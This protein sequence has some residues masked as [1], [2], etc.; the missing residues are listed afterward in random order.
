MATRR[1][2]HR[3]EMQRMPARTPAPPEAPL[4][5]APIPIGFMEIIQVRDVRFLG[6]IPFVTDTADEFVLERTVPCMIWNPVEMSDLMRNMLEGR[7]K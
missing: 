7:S 2:P 4:V 1:P 6:R 5:K 3:K